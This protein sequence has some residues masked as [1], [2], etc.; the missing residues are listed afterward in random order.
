MV[1]RKHMQ[2]HVEPTFGGPGW[3]A[4]P[5]CCRAVTVLRPIVSLPLVME[6]Q[7]NRGVG[8]FS[9]RNTPQRP[10]MLRIR[11]RTL[12]GVDG[13]ATTAVLYRSEGVI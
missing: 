2:A 5:N 1:E 4:R 11:I 6:W 12:V 7:K 9:M 10:V 13:E 8:Q 3:G